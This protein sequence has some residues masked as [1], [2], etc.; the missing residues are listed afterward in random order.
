M[1]IYP[2][3]ATGERRFFLS[4]VVDD[5]TPCTP[6]LMAEGSPLPFPSPSAILG[7]NAPSDSADREPEPP[8]KH[9]RKQSRETK[10]EPL[11][12]RKAPALD[13]PSKDVKPKQTKSRNGTSSHLFVLTRHVLTSERFS[14]RWRSHYSSRTIR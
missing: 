14:R 1:I 13:D 5:P 7:D 6:L 3:S 4:H 12:P 10:K 11:P 2:V 8:K 9:V